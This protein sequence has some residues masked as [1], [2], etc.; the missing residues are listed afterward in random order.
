MT[1]EEAIIAVENES[2]QRICA[3]GQWVVWREGD[4]VMSKDLP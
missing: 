3:P 2:A 1:K 4:V